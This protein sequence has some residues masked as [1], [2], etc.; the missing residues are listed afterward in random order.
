MA[1][2][3][4]VMPWRGFMAVTSNGCAQIQIG[5]AKPQAQ[6][7]IAADIEKGKMPKPDEREAQQHDDVSRGIAPARDRPGK[8]RSRQPAVPPRPSQSKRLVVEPV[9]KPTGVVGKEPEA[10]LNACVDRAVERQQRL[11]EICAGKARGR[12]V[13]HNQAMGKLHRQEDVGRPIARGADPQ[14]VT[15]DDHQY[16]ARL[17]GGGGNIV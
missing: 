2:S 12:A 9:S 3:M 13:N 17:G 1:M 6:R 14:T 5:L 15:L 4:L 10:K 8:D 16:V 7:G 11:K